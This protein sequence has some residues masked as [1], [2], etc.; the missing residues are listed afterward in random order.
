MPKVI[1]IEASG[2]RITAE[3]EEGM[4]VM[5]GAV[6]NMVKGI[7]AECGGACSCGTCH[8]YIDDAWIE[9][10][11]EASADEVEMLDCVADVRPGSRLSCQVAIDK[12]LDGLV[13]Y[14]PA[15]QGY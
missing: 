13:V 12:S 4:T 15:S 2:A 14:L 6:A 9:K 11:G 1:Y 8:C 3:L 7:D 5:Q 10:V